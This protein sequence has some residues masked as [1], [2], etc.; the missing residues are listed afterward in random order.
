MSG[1]VEDMQAFF[2]VG[3]ELSKENVW[4]QWSKTSEFKR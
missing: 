4:P 1:A 3:Y 2:E